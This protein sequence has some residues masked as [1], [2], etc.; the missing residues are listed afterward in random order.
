MKAPE[1]ENLAAPT[2]RSGAATRSA[3]WARE[4][5][6][7]QDPDGRHSTAGDRDGRCSALRPSPALTASR[8]RS[9]SSVTSPV[10]RQRAKKA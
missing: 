9:C 7:D 4:L 2:R 3:A 5:T 6:P 10:S 8:S 1:K